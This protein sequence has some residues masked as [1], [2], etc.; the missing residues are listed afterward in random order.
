[1]SHKVLV[2]PAALPQTVANLKLHLRVDHS[3]DDGLIE[4]FMRTAVNYVEDISGHLLVRRKAVV[5]F[6]AFP[7]GANSIELPFYPVTKISQIT[8]VDNDGAEQTLATS[9]Y[10]LDEYSQPSKVYL[11]Y[12]QS[13]PSTR[14][15][16]NA[17][18]VYFW[19]GHLNDFVADTGADTLTITDHH[20]SDGDSVV[21]FTAGGNA[22]GSLDEDV[23]YYVVNSTAN[24]I[25]LSLT[26]GGGAIDLTGSPSGVVFLG[27]VPQELML[28][29]E[30]L[31]GL[32]YEHRESAIDTVLHQLPFGV[33]AL[34]S[35]KRSW[36]V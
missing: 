13:W 6:D 28:C 33:R 9:V 5:T 31:T 10:E 24:T 3:A 26:E 1:M 21:L 8:Y 11:K 25:Q 22:P 32:Y 35:N 20:Y 19:G 27:D 15:E 4:E 36:K 7:S 34:L 18:K 17:V 12:N 23:T 16:P 30:I 2:R 29:F 14:D